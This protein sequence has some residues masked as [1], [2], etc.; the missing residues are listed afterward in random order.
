MTWLADRALQPGR[1]GAFWFQVWLFG[2]WITGGRSRKSVIR[3]RR[4]HEQVILPTGLTE[5]G[6]ELLD[7]LR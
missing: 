2:R 1:W 7:R 6:R 5:R 3:G 4:A